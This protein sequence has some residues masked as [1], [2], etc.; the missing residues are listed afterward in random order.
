MH[1][2]FTIVKKELK[3][4]FTDIR[5]LLGMIL[6]GL[7]IFLMYSFMGSIITNVEEKQSSYKTFIVRVENTPEE[8]SIK[9]FFKDKKFEITDIYTD[10]DSSTTISKEEF[11]TKISDKE[12]DLYIIYPENFMELAEA[13]R[14]DETKPIPNVEIYYNSSKDESSMIYSEYEAFLLGYEST[15]CNMFDINNPESGTVYNLAKKDDASKKNPGTKIT[16][17]QLE[18]YIGY[19]EVVVDY[20]KKLSELIGVEEIIKQI[21]KA[22]NQ[23]KVSQS[24]SEKGNDVERPSIHMMF[25][26]NPG[27]GKTTIARI[28]A[29][30]MKSAGIL[31]KGNFFEYKGRDLC[32]EYVG[33][34]TPKTT[35]I[36]RDAYGSVLFI[37]EAY[38]LYRGGDSGKDYGRE[39]L[40]ALVAE[41]ENHRDDMCVIFAGYTDEMNTMVKGN[42]GLKSRIP[43][44]IDFPNYDRE[45]LEQIFFKMLEGKF[46][47]EPGVKKAAHEFFSSLGDDVLKSKE[48]SNARFVRNLFESVWGEAALRFDL[49]SDGELKITESDFKTAI[50]RVDLKSMSE[51]KMG[52]IGVVI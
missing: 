6:P 39:A 51:K 29:Q 24:M 31:K 12:A 2:V 3:R 26:G 52:R 49:S 45:Q 46:K 17:K 7:I 20:E 43:I 48:F 41:M 36:C 21:D 22:I 37:D 25:R 42:P 8:E 40:T 14:L 11:M 15:K 47:Y 19:S 30:K 5:V 9:N 27:T 1:S 4:S 10:V 28:V 33:Q 38:E 23:V 34:T 16:G 44:Y 50:D 35:S 18:G 32:A 13:H